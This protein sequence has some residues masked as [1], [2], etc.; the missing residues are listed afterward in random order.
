[1][2]QKQRSTEFN[3]R[4]SENFNVIKP[5]TLLRRKK[6]HRK[7]EEKINYIKNYSRTFNYKIIYE[8][9]SCLRL[10][11]NERIRRFSTFLF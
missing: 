11:T 7:G 4:L 9:I 6:K 1:M 3:Y 5:G 10:P 8:T 2:Q